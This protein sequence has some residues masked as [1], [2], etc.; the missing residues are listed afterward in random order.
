[1]IDKREVLGYEVGT[2]GEEIFKSKSLYYEMKHNAEKYSKLQEL[3]FADYV[4]TVKK[5]VRYRNY[6]YFMEDSIKWLSMREGKLDRRKK[7]EEKESFN[8]LQ[9]A[10]NEDILNKDCVIKGISRLNLDTIA[11]IVEFQYFDKEFELYIPDTT[12]LS[13]K[14]F[15]SVHEGQL[16]LGV[17]TEV[18][19]DLFAF[20]YEESEIR[21]HFNDYIIEHPEFKGDKR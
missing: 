17:K 2:M 13:T 6:S 7:Y 3:S 20:S 21:K 18:G 8:L 11:W 14:N 16:A 15:S 19:Y 9:K 12:K 10:I 4:D 1:M 5:Y